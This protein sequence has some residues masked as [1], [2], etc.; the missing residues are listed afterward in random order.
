MDTS[1]DHG[2]GGEFAY[3]HTAEYHALKRRLL[4]ES[5]HQMNAQVPIERGRPGGPYPSGSPSGYRPPPIQL[6]APD[7]SI[8]LGNFLRFQQC[9]S[10]PP[11]L[12]SSPQPSHPPEPPRSSPPPRTGLVYVYEW[13]SDGDRT[14]YGYG[15]NLAG[16]ARRIVPHNVPPALFVVSTDPQLLAA[17]LHGR[18]EVQ[19]CPRL[20]YRTNNFAVWE[21]MVDPSRAFRNGYLMRIGTGTISDTQKLHG[22]FKR[23]RTAYHFANVS[24]YYDVTIQMMFELLWRKVQAMPLPN[25]HGAGSDDDDGTLYQLPAT[26]LEWFD[27]HLN[28]HR[29]YEPPTLPLI[30]FD[31]ETVS[32][33]PHRVPYGDEPD[34]RLFMVSIHHVRPA[35][36]IFTL[37]YLPL[38]DAS[39]D[40]RR[41]LITED[42]YDVLPGPKSLLPP[43]CRCVLETFGDERALL[44]RTMQLLTLA[45]KLH[46][47]V[48]YNSSLYDMR[49]LLTRCVYFRLT[50]WVERFCYRDGYHQ[51][52]CQIHLDLFRIICMRYRFKSYTLDAVSRE[53][54]GASKT[55]VSAV[56][57][58]YTYHYMAKH[59][60][61]LRHGES[62]PSMPSVR[63]ALHYNNADTL[64]VSKLEQIIDGTNYLLEYSQRVRI[65]LS[66]I[67]NEYN[68]MQR[69]VMTECLIMGLAARVFFG[70]FKSAEVSIGLPVLDEH[71]RWCDAVALDLDPTERLNEIPG[72]PKLARRPTTG[73]GAA[74]F[75]GGFNFCLG[76]LNARPVHAYDYVTAY[77]G[78]IH[79]LNIS[80]ETVAIL[81]ANIL[82]QLYPTVVAREQYRTYDYMVHRGNTK[83][84]SGQ[85]AYRY[86]YEGLYAGGEFPF[87]ADHLRRRHH[88]LVMVVWLGRRGV[89]AEIAAAF[90]EQRIRNNKRY[91][92]M[93]DAHG[94][95]ARRIATIRRN[96]AAA[97]RSNA[98]SGGAAPGGQPS[99]VQ[100]TDPAATPAPAEAN[101]HQFRCAT[102]FLAVNESYHVSLRTAALRNHPDELRA[103]VDLLAQVTI[104]RDLNRNRYE[105]D[106]A[107]VS[108]IYGCLGKSSP[109]LAAF[110]TGFTRNCLI[111][112]AAR[113]VRE[114]FIVYYIDTDS[115]LVSAG[116]NMTAQLNEQHPQFQ[117]ELKVLP[118]CMFLKRKTYITVLDSGELKYLQHVNGPPAWRDFVTFCWKQTDIVTL[119]DVRSVFRKFF[120]QLYDR[121]LRCTSV[122]GTFLALISHTIRVMGDYKTQTPAAKFKAYIAQHYPALAGQRR[123]QIYYDASGG[124][125]EEL[126]MRP[127]EDLR[128]VGDLWRVNAFKNY[129]NMFAVVYILIKSRLR[130]N[131]FPHAVSLSTK[132]GT[133]LMLSGFLDAYMARFGTG[134]HR[135]RTA[136]GTVMLG[137]P[138]TDDPMMID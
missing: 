129:Q 102:R 131:N 128:S 22:E 112:S 27:E 52:A 86:I 40:R 38:P 130:E 103:L 15:C 118:G 95:I 10:A 44:V 47:T 127:I 45:P 136:L 60:R 31:I 68:K 41:Q 23:S 114:G 29:Q 123:Y 133:M 90:N 110:I 74:I 18:Y 135:D 79:R 104:E 3:I 88:S 72:E 20:N 67:N 97:A 101:P 53:L 39:S 120:D 89:L 75:P 108:S 126:V 91:E 12:Q 1:A 96:R 30:T 28:V 81:P 13:R 4:A 7:S 66:I 132:H 36:T 21:Q 107:T 71:N 63:D 58:R 70:T 2:G 73:P 49:Y 8:N 55:G 33:D 48:G 93:V 138:A 46:L 14:I 106:K 56:A 92:T 61:Y 122:D 121:L 119:D 59:N 76:E 125:V 94:L 124:S 62:S 109:V 69:K 43:G 84:E 64:L 32:S 35:N 80:D 98:R 85:L 11:S 51:D 6:P 116:P 134:S 77:T 100:P 5:Y 42:G 87:E 105:L 82:L 115:I 117:M 34:D 24:I 17:Y 78:L 137:E 65:A 113:M 9:P 19:M 111:N 83:S 16:D 50:E 99:K 57:L 25:D 26:T 54:I 37:V